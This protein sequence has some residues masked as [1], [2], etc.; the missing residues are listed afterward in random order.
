MFII[1]ERLKFLARIPAPR[2]RSCSN[3]EEAEPMFGG[4]HG[5]WSLLSHP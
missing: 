4:D 1:E 2:V 5:I 3:Q